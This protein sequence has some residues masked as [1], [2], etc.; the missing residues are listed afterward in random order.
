MIIN[1][2]SDNERKLLK[3]WK[4]L[5]LE[6]SS[7]KALESS[8][9]GVSECKWEGKFTFEMLMQTVDISWWLNLNKFLV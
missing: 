5:S 6:S 1:S 8:F 7:L 3:V 4:K 9:D 2:G